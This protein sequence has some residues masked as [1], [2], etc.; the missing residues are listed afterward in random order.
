MNCEKC[1][2]L[3]DRYIDNE[4]DSTYT[5]SCGMGSINI[6]FAKINF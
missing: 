1:L 2:E 6:N 3:I 4:S 5:L